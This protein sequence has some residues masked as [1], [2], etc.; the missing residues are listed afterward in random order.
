MTDDTTHPTKVTKY[1]YC[2]TVNFETILQKS[3][4][5]LNKIF[6]INICK[7]LI[8]ACGVRYFSQRNNLL[9]L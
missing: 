3:K 6:T 4:I 2:L 1:S 7:I 8:Y 5:D 9:T